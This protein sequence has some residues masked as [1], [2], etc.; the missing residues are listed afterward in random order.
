MALGARSLAIAILV[1]RE[2]S[3]QSGIG[4]GVGLVGGV[5][6]GRYLLAR[7]GASP[8]PVPVFAIG[9]IVTALILTMMLSAIA[10]VWRSWRVDA[11]AVLREDG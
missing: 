10:P 5:V 3:L 1:I 4:L 7:P 8:P 2:A 9:M 6:A 11:A